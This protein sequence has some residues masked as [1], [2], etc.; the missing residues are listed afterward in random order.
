MLGQAMILI[1]TKL[2]SVQLVYRVIDS[3]EEHVRL[4]NA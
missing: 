4:I 1:S 2:S 3:D